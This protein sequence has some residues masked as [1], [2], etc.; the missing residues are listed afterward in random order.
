[1]S[2]AKA[3]SLLLKGKKTTPGVIKKVKGGVEA[4]T[5]IAPS[6]SKELS[7]K[8]MGLKVHG[9]AKRMKQKLKD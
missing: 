6:V 4:I 3:L 2:L 9:W 1:M 5:G 7:K 8:A